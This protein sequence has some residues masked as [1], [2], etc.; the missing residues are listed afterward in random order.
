[1]NRSHS[2]HV[3]GPRGRGWILIAVA[4]ALSAVACKKS[5]EG[6]EADL[7]DRLQSECYRDLHEGT[8]LRTAPNGASCSN[9]GYGDCGDELA[10]ECVNYCAFDLCQA[11]PCVGD[12][13]CAAYGDGAT[14][15][16]YEVEGVPSYGRWCRPGQGGGS[17]STCDDACLDTC[18]VGIDCL[19]ICCS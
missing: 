8:P 12:G 6:D 1:M 2:N 15:E 17:G 9:F 14:C 11:A 18:T 10:S 13:D 19:S 5:E 3:W 7:F 4:I 16:E